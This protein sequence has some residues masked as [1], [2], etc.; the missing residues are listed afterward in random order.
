MDNLFFGLHIASMIGTAFTLYTKGSPYVKQFINHPSIRQHRIK[1]VDFRK[2][3]IINEDIFSSM[4]AGLF[5]LALGR[6]LWPVCLPY[7]MWYIQRRYELHKY[8]K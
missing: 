5:G 2:T 6:Y 7:S 1:I 3:D 4:T 8:F